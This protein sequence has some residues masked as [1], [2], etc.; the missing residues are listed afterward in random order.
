MNTIYLESF[1]GKIL[2]KNEIEVTV[3]RIWILKYYSLILIV[4]IYN[5]NKRVINVKKMLI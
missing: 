4:S 3:K 5:V 1:N 2:D